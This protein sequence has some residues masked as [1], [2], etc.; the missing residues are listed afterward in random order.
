MTIL[1]AA[2][3]AEATVKIGS[4]CNNGGQLACSNNRKFQVSLR[5]V[6][7][8]LGKLMNPARSDAT[9]TSGSS[10][11][12]ATVLCA[13]VGNAEGEMSDISSCMCGG[14]KG[15]GHWTVVTVVV[16]RSAGC[17]IQHGRLV[18]EN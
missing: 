6:V 11:R 16:D 5:P 14:K 4:P 8:S 18:G 13:P 7:A 15:G 10:T 17:A 2:M 9:E 3:S 12:H 1:A